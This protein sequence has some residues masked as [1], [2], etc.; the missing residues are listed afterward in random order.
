V[1]SPSPSQAKYESATLNTCSI[2]SIVAIDILWKKLL[3]SS[4]RGASFHTKHAKNANVVRVVLLDA[5]SYLA[6]WYECS[7]SFS[8]LLRHSRKKG[9]GAI[10]FFCT[11]RT[12]SISYIWTLSAPDHW[13]TG[14]FVVFLL[15]FC[16]RQRIP[17]FHQLIFTNPQQTTLFFWIANARILVKFTAKY[18]LM[19]PYYI[20]TTI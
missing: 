3:R 18:N 17:F 10:P 7:W 1:V 14:S 9:R 5:N 19:V 8:L 16:N 20:S 2:A 4:G 12:L 6:L 13:W 11:L 15:T